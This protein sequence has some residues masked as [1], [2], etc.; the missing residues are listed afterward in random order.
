MTVLPLA[1]AESLGSTARVSS[2]YLVGALLAVAATL[3]VGS[4]EALQRRRGVV[5]LSATAFVVA[6]GLIVIGKGP[7]I[8]LGIGLVAAEAAMFSVCLSLFI[9]DYIGKADLQ[10]NESRRM[11]YAGLAWMAG[12]MLATVL[13]NKVGTAVP[14]AVAAALMVVTLVY[15]WILRLGSDP[16][17][18]EPKS[19]PPNPMQNI[20]AYFRQRYLRIA[21]AITLTRGTFWAAFFIYAPLYV[22]DAGLPAWTAGGIV[23]AIAVLLLLSPAAL[24]L[25]D[26]TNTRTVISA[27]FVIIAVSLGCLGAVGDPR[28]VG[29]V[30]WLTAAYG[31]TWLDVLGNIPFMR[32]VKP[33]QRI[34]MTT[35]FSSWRE[36]SSFAAPALAAIVLVLGPFWIFYFVLAAGCLATAAYATYL[37]ARL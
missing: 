37:P 17:I 29:V 32:T 12:P 2:A 7:S 31:A 8:A 5:S 30:F 15:F 1:A 33:R 3:H 19:K 35:V 14:F 26:R 11:V 28:P 25:V 13:Y 20:P 9:M 23:T 10:R 16:V 18:A 24:R 34:P 21:Y 4:L 22:L 27:G 6:N 36:T